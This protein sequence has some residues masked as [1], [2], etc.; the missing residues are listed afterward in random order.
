MRVIAG[1]AR[2]VPLKF[3]SGD[4][5]RPTSDKI[6]E[7]LFNILQT[8][9]YGSK[10]LDLFAGSGQMGI[11]ALSRG[12]DFAAFVDSDR[13]CVSL[14]QE[15]LEKTKLMDYAVV[16]SRILPKSLGLLKKYGP[17]DIIFMDPPYA[18]GIEPKVLSAIEKHSLCDETTLI[19]METER[20]RDLSFLEESAFTAT[21]T[22]VYRTNQHVFL[23]WENV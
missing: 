16:L 10:F 8:E 23:K 15:N 20:G 2:S 9:I 17:F 12:A 13:T 18:L 3:P 4:F 6:K 5:C 14:I 7:T 1:S 11:E 21:R 22:K 19:I